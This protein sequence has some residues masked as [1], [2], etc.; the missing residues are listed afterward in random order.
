MNN[1]E[2]VSKISAQIIFNESLLHFYVT[3]AI[4]KNIES[5]IINLSAQFSMTPFVVLFAHFM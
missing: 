2:V 4:L 1:K 3:C 5:V